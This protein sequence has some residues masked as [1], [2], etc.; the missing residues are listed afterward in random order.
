MA[1]LKTIMESGPSSTLVA[2]FLYFDACLAV[3]V[4]SGAIGSSIT[5]AHGLS[6]QQTGFMISVP[7]L[8]GALMH[9]L[10]GIVLVLTLP[11][12]DLRGCRPARATS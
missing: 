7:I 12:A 2:A 3:W 1:N 11:N 8:P 4:L 5:Q 9:F 10:L 6:P